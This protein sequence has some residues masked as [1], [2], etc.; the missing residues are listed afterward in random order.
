MDK[1][2][3]HPDQDSYSFTDGL[4]T[5][6]EQFSGGQGRY[7]TGIVNA[8]IMLDVTWTCD[9]TEFAYMR[10]TYA[11]HV[12]EGH[13][14]FAM[15]LVIDTWT[16]VEHQVRMMPGT[17]G[18]NSH[19]GKQYIV[20]CTLEV[21]P[22]RKS[23]VS[24]A[25]LK[26]LIPP[27]PDGYQFKDTTQV[28]HIPLDGGL[29]RTKRD[30]D[31]A[32]TVVNVTWRTNAAGLLY[33]RDFYRTW[34][35]SNEKA[36]GFPIDLII[37]GAAPAEVFCN[38]IPG[39]MKLS[40]V[41]GHTYTLTALLESVVL[42]NAPEECD[43]SMIAWSH[44]FETGAPVRGGFTYYIGPGNDE[45][46]RSPLYGESSRWWGN[47]LSDEIFLSNPAVTIDG[48]WSIYTSFKFYPDSLNGEGD[49]DLF[50][51]WNPA[52]D[53]N[54]VRI[55][56]EE[57]DDGGTPRL[58]LS[59][60]YVPSFSQHEV[61]GFDYDTTLDMCFVMNETHFYSFVN[62]VLIDTQTIG[63]PAPGIGSIDLMWN[64][65][66]QLGQVVTVDEIHV[67]NVA[68]HTE[69]Y[70]VDLPRCT[71]PLAPVDIGWYGDPRVPGE[72]TPAVENFGQD[73]NVSSTDELDLSFALLEGPF[74]SAV[75]FG[76]VP[77]LLGSPQPIITPTGGLS[78]KITPQYDSDI[79]R[80]YDGVIYISGD[81][82]NGYL[83][84]TIYHD[85]T[86]SGYGGVA[87]SHSA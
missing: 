12:L 39:S 73:S 6:R 55:W 80:M 69:S 10:A 71:C 52:G 13:A 20:G 33:L 24:G 51:I 78:F 56:I 57:Y 76:W 70:T 19:R 66:K 42:P 79:N 62:G 21:Q 49:W 47:A 86:T 22:I 67:V 30:L 45:F 85:E 5:L 18:L 61:G 41:N 27:V 74:R 84:L 1:L 8:A 32:S 65:F 31:G 37:D 81:G 2:T 4:E 87:W 29:G 28:I 26:L 25:L 64:E 72:T 83:M 9:P 38:F 63:S 16:F 34:V 59:I 48:N 7:R 14:P 40:S 23:L 54:Y 82:I 35:M 43:C 17:F 46:S 11:Q 58:K 68:E 15:D 60:F 50:K 53:D 44:S 36:T 3:L 75:A 77:V